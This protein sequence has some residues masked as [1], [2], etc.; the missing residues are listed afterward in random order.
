MNGI[1]LAL[2]WICSPG[3]L[4]PASAASSCLP[5][6][7]RKQEPKSDQTSGIKGE[8]SL[9]PLV[10]W[11][12]TEANSSPDL[13]ERRWVPHLITHICTRC[14]RQMCQLAALQQKHSLP[15]QKRGMSVFGLY[16]SDHLLFLSLGPL[17]TLLGDQIWWCLRNYLQC[18]RLKLGQPHAFPLY[19][20]SNP[21][22]F[23][24][25]NKL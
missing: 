6:I 18:F 9:L 21:S 14:P 12:K 2:D 3:R 5:L 20:F 19:H 11:H 16:W 4:G 1:S 13:A 17:L 8:T 10:Q 23:F 7:L 15:I 24:C 22:F 25:S